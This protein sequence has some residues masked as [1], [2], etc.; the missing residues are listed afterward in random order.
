MNC[1]TKM[2]MEDLKVDLETALKVQRIMMC[3]DLRFSSASRRQ[4]KKAAQEAFVELGERESHAAID[5]MIG[6]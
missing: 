5:R 3:S 1:Y 6:A 2:I 4:L